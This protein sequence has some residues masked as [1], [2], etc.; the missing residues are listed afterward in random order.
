MT[1]SDTHAHLSLVAEELGID[2]LRGVIAEYEAARA[3]AAK[4]GRGG[5]LL[6][7]PGVDAGDL[8]PR[9][10]L[11]GEAGALPGDGS[12]LRLAA[13]VWPSAAA[14]AD[15]SAAAAALEASVAESAIAGRPCAAIGECGLDY[16]HMEGPRERQMEL[17]EAQLALAGRLGLPLVVHS[18]DAFDDTLALLAGARLSRP[19]VVHCFGYGAREARALLD[20]GCYVSFAG[21][22]TYKKSGALRDACALVPLDRLLLETDAPYMCPEP[23]RG[24]PSTPLDVGRTYAAAAAV[25]GAAVAELSQAVSDN[26]VAIFGR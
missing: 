16:H 21:N 26:A 6:V 14:L 12:F 11:L 18:R 17:F 8:G 22:L 13:G 7:D 4:E 5:P 24:R 23:R 3:G 20:L 9:A 15:P 2:A 10:A 25:R 19:I 1:F